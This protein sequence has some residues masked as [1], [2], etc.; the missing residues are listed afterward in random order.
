MLRFGHNLL[1]RT[2]TAAAAVAGAAAITSAAT[3]TSASATASSFGESRTDERLKVLITGFNDWHELDNNVWRCVDNPACRLLVG[4]PCNSPPLVRHGPLVL[5]IREALGNSVECHFQTL[6]VTWGTASGLDLMQF[7]LVVHLGLG[8]YDCHDNILLEHNAYNLRCDKPDALACKGGGTAITVD[9]AE[10]FEPAALATRY[11][12]LALGDTSLPGGF[13]LSTAEA[14]SVNTYICNETHWRA[15]KAVEA[16]AE[17]PPSGGHQP[18]RLRSA[19]FI[20]LP[21]ASD[22]LGGYKGLARAVAEVISRIVKL[23]TGV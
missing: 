20:H 14:R 21:H 6:P 19:Y 10:T 13:R 15:L 23:E 2:Y 9:A 5:A 18:P 1:R 8:V 4:P 16:A 22:D 3:T 11:A 12:L 17:A 7:D